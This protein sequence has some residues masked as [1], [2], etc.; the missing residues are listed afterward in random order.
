MTGDSLLSSG[1]KVQRRG[2]LIATC[3]LSVAAFMPAV[4]TASAQDATGSTA[5]GGQVETV[6]VTAEK[7]NQRLVDVPTSISVVTAQD[8][9]NKNLVSLSDIASRV[10]NVVISGSNNYPNI[11]I[12]GVGSPSGTNPGFAPAAAVYVDDVYQGRERGANIPLSGID[13][14]EVLRGPQ[15]TLYGKNTIAGALNITTQKPTDQ[16]MASG[17]VQYG[18]FN[19][20]QLEGS[21]SGPLTDDLFIGGSGYYRYRDGYIRNEFDNSRLNGDNV[22]AGRLRAIYT[23]TS[24]LTIDVGADYLK[25]KDSGAFLTTDYSVIQQIPFPPYNTVTAFDPKQRRESMN[26]PNFDSREVHGV[27]VRADYDFDGMRLTSITALRGYVSFFAGDTDGT[28]LNIDSE[29]S[30]DRA[31]QFSQEVRLTST[32]Q[33]PFQ[34]IIGGYFYQQNLHDDFT[35]NIGDQ[36]PAFLI[37]AG[38]LPPGYSDTGATHT[39]ISENNFAGFISGTYDILPDLRLAGGI[40]FTSDTQTLNFSQQNVTNIQ[41]QLVSIL[42]ANIPQRREHIGENEPTYDASLS[43]KFTDEQ[44]GY[45]K[46]SRGYKSGGFNAITITPPFDLSNSLAFKPEFLNN[47]EVGFKGAF[48]GGLLSINADGFYDEYTN[49]QE[50]V[51]NLFSVVVRNAAKARV[52]GAEL[53][54]DANPLEGLNIS[55]TLGVLNGTYTDFPNANLPNACDC[56]TGNRLA[57]APA[58]QAAVSAQYEHELPF[59]DGYS[60]FGRLEYIT[61]SKSYIDPNNTAAYA[62]QPYSLF[63]AKLGIEDEHWGAYFWGKNLTNTFILSSGQNQLVT[64]GRVVNIPRTIGIEVSYKN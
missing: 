55:G 52:Y 46:F 36:F 63:N 1:G 47:Y 58:M 48:W 44:V 26:S 64:T 7:R 14:I 60:G 33:G 39:H 62:T 23:P 32:D 56:A 18:S 31:N 41:P 11:T 17:D 34:W 22:G 50:S 4:Q 8:I 13:Q 57:N 53:E 5:T 15:G 25:E 38:F 20:T 54:V 28:A 29:T 37:G 6:V 42:L 2:A 10:P 24:R 35:V 45:L 12:R 19:F 30:A 59:W 51:L 49:K 21:M 61:Q 40:R 16:F 9:Q 27:S 3:A 43:Y